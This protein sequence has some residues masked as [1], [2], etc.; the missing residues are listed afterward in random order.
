MKYSYVPESGPASDAYDPWSN[1]CRKL[2]PA[3]EVTSHDLSDFVIP[4]A[5]LSLAEFGREQSWEVKVQYSRGNAPH[6]KTGQPGAL[7]DFVAVR[8]RGHPMTDRQAYAVYSRPAG[9]HAGTWT[10]SSVM[11]WGPDL[12]P[13]AGCGITEL[14]AYLMMCADSSAEGLASWIETLKQIKINGETLKRHRDIA[15]KHVVEMSERQLHDQ[16]R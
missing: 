7:R 11:I 2:F 8:F 14:K 5:A 1:F 10:W 6:A 15:R 12:P 3:P 16:I 13:Y 4:R 9:P